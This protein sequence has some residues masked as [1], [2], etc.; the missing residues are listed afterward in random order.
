[1]RANHAQSNP[2]NK[3]MPATNPQNIA[4]TAG[5]R[6]GV[7]EVLYRILDAAS[8]DTANQPTEFNSGAPNGF[9]PSIQRQYPS[10]PAIARSIGASTDVAIRAVS[11]TAQ[12]PP[13]NRRAT[14]KEPPTIIVQAN[15]SNSGNAPIEP[16]CTVGHHF[17]EYSYR[18]NGYPVARP[19]ISATTPIPP[20]HATD[21]QSANSIAT[22]PKPD[23]I[24]RN[25]AIG[26][27]GPGYAAYRRDWWVT[28]CHHTG[29]VCE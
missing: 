17:V 18:P 28:A 25:P 9:P 3:P 10:E 6:E 22:T 14:I 29:K 21:R 27:I 16:R 13:L 12:I 7:V 24:N 4:S 8:A 20:I 5:P 11:T 19:A 23:M 15:G 1:M 26:A 2:S